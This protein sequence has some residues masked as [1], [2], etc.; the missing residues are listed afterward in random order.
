MDSITI[1]D[2]IGNCDDNGVPTGHVVKTINEAVEMLRD[3]F[4]VNLAIASNYRKYVPT[5]LSIYPLSYDA[6]PSTQDSIFK[7]LSIL[8]KRITAIRKIIAQNNKIWFLNTDFWLYVAIV[9]CKIRTNQEIYITNYLDFYNKGSFGKDLKNTIYRRACKKVKCVFTTDPSIVLKNHIFIPDYWYDRSKYELYK[10]E[11]KVKAVYICGGINPG[12]D[13]EG[14]INAF[15]RNNQ[16]L[17]VCGNFSSDEILQQS[18]RTANDNI[19]ISHGRM[20][21]EEYYRNLGRYEYVLLPYKKENYENRSS[22]VILEALFL[23]AI[24][25]APNFLL[26]HLGIAGIGYDLIDEL[27]SLDLNR[28]NA[29]LLQEIKENNQRILDEYSY[30]KIRAKYLDAFQN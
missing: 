2:Y 23:G 17:V 20:T 13:I 18:R 1:V 15:N 11:V 6:R 14:T 26:N 9:S 27:D 12:K 16:Q 29:S 22:G 3:N 8:R 25:I 10:A 5:N 24:V 7:K 21:D 30:E 4:E 19:K 28:V